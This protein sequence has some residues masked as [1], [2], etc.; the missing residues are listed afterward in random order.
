MP[1][2]TMLA[3][4]PDRGDGCRLSATAAGQVA[5]AT[6]CVSFRAHAM[7]SASGRLQQQRIQARHPGLGVLLN[8][9]GP[10]GVTCCCA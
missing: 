1:W 9:P 4:T 6:R 10:N 2:L 5:V 8:I 3:G 7:R